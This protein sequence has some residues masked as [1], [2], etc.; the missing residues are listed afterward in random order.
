[1]DLGPPSLRNHQTDQITRRVHSG[2]FRTVPERLRS[3]Q[4][5]S[6]MRPFLQQNCSSITVKLNMFQMSLRSPCK[7]RR[8]RLQDVAPSFRG[9]LCRNPQR[10]PNA[11]RVC[12]EAAQQCLV[13]NSSGHT[14]HT[15][16]YH[17]LFV[18]TSVMFS[19]FLSLF[20]P[21]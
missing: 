1:M 17:L 16:L 19:L 14:M 12:W 5:T 7:Q 3:P 20:G 10:A 13:G 8:C 6:K 2:T 11:R 21:A 9:G 4:G 18:S 15:R